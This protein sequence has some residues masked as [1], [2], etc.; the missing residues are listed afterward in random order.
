MLKPD[1][2]PIS[3][4]EI[5]DILWL[6]ARTAP[7]AQTRDH[8]EPTQDAPRP[9][10]RGGAD[11]GTE[12][13][14]PQQGLPQS[15]DASVDIPPDEGHPD[16]QERDAGLYPDV[17]A[18]S[19][20][21]ASSGTPFRVSAAEALSRHE[22]R[23]ISRALRPLQRR[24]LS[25]SRTQLAENATVEQIAA[26]LLAGRP[27]WQ[28][29]TVPETER[30][31]DVVLLVDGSPSMMIWQ[32][33][34][35]AVAQ[36]LRDV[37]IFRDV[38]QFTLRVVEAAGINNPDPQVT[39]VE[40]VAADSV[41]RASELVDAAGRRLFLVLSDCS[42][43][44]WDNGAMSRLLQPFV[45]HNCVSIW[46]ILPESLWKTTAL[47]HAKQTWL[48]AV[49]MLQNE[50]ALHIN[51]QAI[52]VVPLAAEP[53]M[54][55]ANWLTGR[56]EDRLA[57]YTFS[58]SHQ[59]RQED[60]N[61]RLH[62][63]GIVRAPTAST[64]E[65]RYDHFREHRPQRVQALASYLA[66]VPLTPPI[67]RMVQRT[68]LPHS[69]H[70]DLAYVFYSGL[71]Q[72]QTPQHADLLPEQIYY[73]FAGDDEQMRDLLLSKIPT[74]QVETLFDHLTDYIIEN[75]DKL[76][77]F[78]VV[79]GVGGRA[80]S[81]AVDSSLQRHFAKVSRHVLT[82]LGGIYAEIAADFEAYIDE[83]YRLRHE[84]EDEPDEEIPLE[85]QFDALWERVHGRATS[86]LGDLTLV[87]ESIGGSQTLIGR[88]RIALD[89]DSE[90]VLPM[91]EDSTIDTT[92]LRIHQPFV[93][94]AQK[95][96]RKLWRMLTEALREPP[97][98]IPSSDVQLPHTQ[99]DTSPLAIGWCWVPARA[100][101]MGS[102]QY[103]DEKPIH[104]R[105]VD[106]F[107][108]MKQPV[109]NAQ[110]A[111]FVD[112]GG[113]EKPR[114]WSEGG[115]RTKVE[116]EWQEPREWHNDR[117]NGALQPVVGVSW[118]EAEAFCNWAS[119][120]CGMTIRLPTEAEW[121]KAARG[122]DGREYPWGNERPNE[123]LA[124]FASNVGQTTPLNRYSPQGDSPY[125]CTDMAGNV[126]EW[127]SSWYKAY[128]GNTI[129]DNNY[130]ETHRVVRGG[131]WDDSYDDILRAASRVRNSPD[132][133]DRTLGFRCASTPF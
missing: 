73:E 46:Q 15:D 69:E 105:H 103:D 100:F 97:L 116:K 54:Q 107:W 8:G 95:Q 43:V 122:N 53:L 115:W 121:E 63:L 41:R 90:N 131:S 78:G 133:W 87:V 113:Y 52:P 61:S 26:S 17:P 45:M 49:D 11:V 81:V 33:T 31:L 12:K 80:A 114:W 56:G 101:A 28:P 68:M 92:S 67:M 75:I 126:D 83:F 99:T 23:A 13:P 104:N 118:F 60:V 38:Q 119:E 35:T 96:Q 125:G 9:A 48:S 37:G 47:T 27:T 124:N 82:Y 22:R 3:A 65:D 76:A 4:E 14:P 74:F 106:A 7:L 6:A 1:D 93:E 129:E 29:V 85:E 16:S 2:R 89:G 123:K 79:L 111:Q 20:Q 112:A 109:T 57:A 91:S 36:L 108:M 30:W 10:A 39:T 18:P 59:V 50:R 77:Q 110:F 102:E 40:L 117:F 70:S 21:G 19:E 51:A 5:A 84:K 72:R 55:W 128:P 64:A 71:L 132:N 98:P 34:I 88:T 120:H 94:T 32:D 62:R 127:T 25:S 58:P 42:S 44:V 130:G 24:I 66:A 86:L